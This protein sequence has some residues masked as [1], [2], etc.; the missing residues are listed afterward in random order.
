MR[1]STIGRV[2][3]RH[4]RLIVALGA[5]GAVLGG[6]ASL[7]LGP[8]YAS[9]SKVLVRGVSEEETLVAEAQIAKSRIVLERTA[10]IL[11]VSGAELDGSVTVTPADGN[12]LV[13]RGTGPTPAAAREV[14]ALATEQYMRFSGELASEGVSETIRVLTDV[15]QTLEI[16]VVDLNAQVAQLRGSGAAAASSSGE[17]ERLQ[18]ELTEATEALD[19]VEGALEDGPAGSRGSISVIEPAA[20]PTG[21]AP[22]TLVHLVGG[23]AGLLAVLGAAGVLVAR[24]RDDRL[25]RGADIAAALDGPILASLPD[26]PGTALE[27]GASRSARR[28]WA[29]RIRWLLREDRRWDVPPGSDTSVRRAAD[30][31]CREV[32]A[33]LR[34]SGSAGPVLVVVHDDDALARVAVARL[35]LVAAADGPVTVV[36]DDPDL[37]TL[38]AIADGTGTDSPRVTF[39]DPDGEPPAGHTVMRVAAVLAAR[40]VIPS[41]GGA[42]GALVVLTAGTRT[43][44]ELVGLAEACA[45]AGHAVAGALLVAPMSGWES[46]RERAPAPA[47]V[48]RRNG[49]PVAGVMGR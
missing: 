24:S 1:L 15:Q 22:P 5:L 8:G 45:D 21:P 30:A 12:V 20:E 18:A 23:G 25:R 7:L 10:E 36:T 27:K 17:L 14:T 2:L 41:C 47:A 46:D 16:R 38:V 3:R 9:T 42:A 39:T 26:Q 33:R 32:M 48:P 13:I 19:G 34:L 44:W 31:R 37:E 35:A 28:T 4:W 29:A 6:L 40:P 11:G 43:G 49:A